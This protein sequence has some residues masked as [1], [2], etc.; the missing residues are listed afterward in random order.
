[1]GDPGAQAQVRLD[2]EVPARGRAGAP[3]AV[4][5][6]LRNGGA[7]SQTVYLRG[8]EIVFDLVVTDSTGTTIWRR[9]EGE[10][11]PAIVQ[12]RVLAPGEEVIIPGRWTA[13]DQAGDP[14]LPGRYLMQASLLTDAVPILS[15]TVT[16]VLANP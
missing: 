6:R 2:L 4:V 12:V 15:P 8:R 1:M 16:L 5:L 13:R 7:D 3:V 9:L 11:I 10:V 14:V